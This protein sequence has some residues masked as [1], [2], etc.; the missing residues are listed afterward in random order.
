MPAESL[1]DETADDSVAPVPDAESWLHP[2]V[3]VR[4]SM[5]AGHGLFTTEPLGAGTLVARLGG[6]LQTVGFVAPVVLAVDEDQVLVPTDGSALHLTNH[7][8]DP[9]LGWAGAYTLVTLRDLEAGVE[10]THDY[11]TSIVD[12]QLMLRCHCETYRCR[13]LIEGDDWA[14][15]QLQTRYAGHLT[16]LLR[17]RIEAAARR[18]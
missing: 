8:C 17:R 9:T 10:L 2:G 15:P 14:I 18:P 3:E 6:V 16:P 12:P 4:L 13:Q 1:S 5:I 11:A 7:S